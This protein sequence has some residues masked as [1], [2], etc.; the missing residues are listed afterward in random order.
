LTKEIVETM[1]KDSIVF[2]LA[3]PTPEIMPEVA[4]AGGARVVA[5]GRS[6]FPNQINNVLVFPGMFNGVLKVR[7]KEICDQMKI[8]VAKGIAGL[9]KDS[10]LTEN[11]IVP[12]VF[13]EGVSETVSKAVVDTARE[14]GLVRKNL[15]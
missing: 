2:A 3:N 9:I 11:N 7:A 10:E 6:D 4:K 14:L 8:A 13:E 1:N 15:M 5:T 12:S